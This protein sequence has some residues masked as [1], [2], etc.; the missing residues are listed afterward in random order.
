MTGLFAATGDNSSNGFFDGV[1]DFFHSGTWYVIRN[2][3]LFFVVVFWL[4]SVYWVYKDARRRVGDPW[5]VAMATILGFLPFLG[6]LI[7]MLFRPPEYLQDVHERELE[8]RAMEDRLRTRDLHCPVCRAEVDP[9]YLAC[10]VCTT[11]LKQA[12]SSCRAPLEALWQVCPFCETRVERGTTIE[13]GLAEEHLAPV[14][15]PLRTAPRRRKPAQP[16]Q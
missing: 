7:Y 6:P 15:A 16:Q 5:L 1:H 12:C 3:L 11:K 4:S 10:P 8:I 2:L 13:L 14:E 9:S